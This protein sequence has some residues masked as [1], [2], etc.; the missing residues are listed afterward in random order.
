VSFTAIEFPPVKAKF[1]RVTQP[2]VVQGLFWSKARASAKRP[3]HTPK[4]LNAIDSIHQNV[5]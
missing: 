4:R 1:I 3:L 2:G 5:E